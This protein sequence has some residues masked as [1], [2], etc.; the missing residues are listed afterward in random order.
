[1]GEKAAI[2]KCNLMIRDELDGNLVSADGTFSET[3]ELQSIQPSFSSV[4]YKIHSTGYYIPAGILM[5]VSW[6]NTNK[7]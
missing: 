2:L 7:P 5:E 1:M 3:P 4:G 6:S